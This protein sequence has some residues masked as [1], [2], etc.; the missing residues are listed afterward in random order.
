MS[1]AHERFL[2]KWLLSF[3]NKRCSIMLTRNIVA[4]GYEG[5]RQTS[6]QAPHF[7]VTLPVLRG[8]IRLL[9]LTC[10][11][12][13]SRK[14]EQPRNNRIINGKLP[15][16]VEQDCQW[17]RRLYQ[18]EIVPC[19]HL[20]GPTNRSN[21]LI[22]RSHGCFNNGRSPRPSSLPQLVSAMTSI[23]KSLLH[24]LLFRVDISYSSLGRKISC[25]DRGVPE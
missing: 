12:E 4:Y 24:F 11:H 18:F 16:V 13:F 7:D 19:Q 8:L 21:F 17:G 10:L 20:N 15:N 22:S 2:N 6:C 9:Q 23:W 5:T 1:I 25:C 14:A 3:Y